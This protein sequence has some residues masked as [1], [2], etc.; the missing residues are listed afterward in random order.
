ML[1]Y[2]VINKSNGKI[3]IG[4]TQS[5]NHLLRWKQH[6]QQAKAGSQLYF[7][8]AIRKYGPNNFEISIMKRANN[9]LVLERLER[10]FIRLN[11]SDE[12]EIGYNMTK[13]GIGFFGSHSIATRKKMSKSRRGNKYALGV[14]HSRQARIN[15]GKSHIGSHRSMAT[16]R[17]IARALI[18]NKNPLGTVRSKAF[19]R[20]I[21]ARFIGNNYGTG[22]RSKEFCR[23]VSLRNMGNRYKTVWKER[24]MK[25]VL[26]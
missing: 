1:I 8:R 10:Q 23:Q 2:R 12:H 5:N 11:R 14:R 7:H 24:L 17:K 25:G 22:K 9:S 13:G 6:I 21:S 18:G 3:Y 15:M 26:T 19:C 4:K 20:A 16:R